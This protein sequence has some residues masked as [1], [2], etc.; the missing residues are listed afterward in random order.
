MEQDQQEQLVAEDW[1]VVIGVVTRPSGLKGEVRV[2]PF[3]D[4]VERFGELEEV[5]VFPPK[6][7]PWLVRPTHWRTH[8]GWVFLTIEGVRD[9]AGAEAMRDAE[10]RIRKDMRYELEE[11]AYWVED[12]VGMV[13]ETDDGRSL[14]TIREVLQ[15]P[16][17]DVYVTEHCLIPAVR[18]MLVSVDIE[19]RK[20]IVRAIPGLAPELGI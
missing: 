17:N 3:T 12:L 2:K 20:M 13:A 8:A 11:G 4:R 15:Y 14:G 18:E 1:C 5:A 6:G 9:L 16:A 10:L 7:Q 19:G